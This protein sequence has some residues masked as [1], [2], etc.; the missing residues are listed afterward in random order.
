MLLRRT[1]LLVPVL[2]FGLILELCAQTIPPRGG[3]ETL[4]IATWNIEW[5][6]D[7]ENG[8]NDL[9][10]Q[11]NNVKAII[12]QSG[13]DIWGVQEIANPD[14]FAR[15][16]G[17]LG[18]EFDGFLGTELWYGQRQN[19]GFIYRTSVITRRSQRHIMQNYGWEFAGRPPLE[20]RADVSLPD[21]SFSATF[22]VFHAKA[23]SG[24]QDWER[25]DEA[26]RRLKFFLDYSGEYNDALFLKGD[27]NDMVLSSTVSGQPSPYRNFVQDPANYRVLTTEAESAGM[28]SWCSRRP[29]D[30][31]T[32]SMIDHITVTR[33]VFPYYVEGSALPYTELLGAVHN[34]RFSTSDHLPVTAHFEFS[35][36][37]SA[38]EMAWYD[39]ATSVAAPYPNP[40]TGTLTIPL[41]LSSPTAVQVRVVDLLG[42]TVAMRDDGILTA[43][44]HEL[45]V[46]LSQVAAGVYVVQVTAGGTRHARRV[47]VTH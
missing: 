44:T 17:E 43:G 7:A 38:S 47:F 25:R 31:S 1:T 16:L 9:E 3:D 46:D 2:A 28:I 26:S 8:L 19:V 6:G 21:T 29:G 5:F 23:M 4:D 10:R 18:E 24:M 33:H 40:T 22:I 37:T 36:T 41:A 34:Y 39:G 45:G 35:T 20:M 11:F 30:C 27:Y 42:R 15:L 13:I 14:Q 32:G 12:E